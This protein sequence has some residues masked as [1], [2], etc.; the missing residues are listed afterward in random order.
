MTMVIIMKT[1]IMLMMMRWKGKEN[2]ECCCVISAKSC[3]FHKEILIIMMRQ[4]DLETS[5]R[6]D[7]AFISVCI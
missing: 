2:R 4:V 6:K 1:M 5:E 3:D 7:L